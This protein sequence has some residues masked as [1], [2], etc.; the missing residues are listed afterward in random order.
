MPAV[1]YSLVGW[2]VLTDSCFPVTTHLT[3]TVG[4]IL[5]QLLGSNLKP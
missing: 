1:Y 4:K 5:S 3:R 2:Q